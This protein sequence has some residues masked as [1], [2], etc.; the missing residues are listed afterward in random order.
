MG[1]GTSI[2]NNELRSLAKNCNVAEIGEKITEETMALLI[3]Q[4]VSLVVYSYNPMFEEI[5]KIKGKINYTFCKTEIFAYENLEIANCDLL[6][7]NPLKYNLL[8]KCHKNVNKWIALKS[9]GNDD[10]LLVLQH[11]LEQ[12]PEWSIIY[13]NT[14]PSKKYG[15]N[16]LT[17]LSRFPA[18]KFIIPV[19]P[20]V[21][22]RTHQDSISVCNSCVFRRQNRC[23]ISGGYL[24]RM[25]KDNE[26]TWVS[27]ACP[28][29]TRKKS[30][31]SLSRKFFV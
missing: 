18:D 9:P 23:T 3:G 6:L 11:F 8:Y 31:S 28:I 12:Y 5:E 1:F 25:T 20:Q 16:T 2:N 17:I 4:P 13:H 26:T 27:D 24:G 10:A 21:V 19:M 22:F 30:S 14:D 7:I 15:D 29:A